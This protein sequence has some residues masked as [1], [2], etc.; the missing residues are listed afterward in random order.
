MKIVKFISI[1]LLGLI[2]VL[3]GLSSCSSFKKPGTEVTG[4]FSKSKYQSS[5]TYFRGVGM[6]QSKDMNTSKS[7]AMIVAKQRLASS[8]NTTMKTVADRYVAE[9]EMENASEFLSK[10]EE[11]NREVTNTNIAD[12]RTIG[13][14]TF[15]LEDGRYETHIALEIHKRSMYRHMKKQAQAKQ[16]WNEAERASMDKFFD[17]LIEEL[18]D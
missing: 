11:L 17:D 8:V 5:R 14:R 4:P 18:R 2:T 16:R 13:E 1:S 12:I 7:K 15:Q 9:R 10:F 3:G 6:G